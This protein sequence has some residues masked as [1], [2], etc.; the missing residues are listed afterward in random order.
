MLVFR[1]MPVATDRTI[2][3]VVWL[4][5]RL[6][7]LLLL[8]L[9]ANAL[10][11][12]DGLAQPVCSAR[13]DIG[14]NMLGTWTQ[15]RSACEED[16]R[17]YIASNPTGFSWFANAANGFAGFPYILQRV[18]P[19]L[20]PEIWGR[21]EEK[22]ARFG[23]FEDP[24]PL[25]PL[26]RGLGI[27][28]AA[29]RA[30]E[31]GAVSP[32]G[33]IDFAKPGLHVV[34]LSCGAC[35]S[36]RVRTDAGVKVIEGAP[37]T[38]MDVRKW[39]DAYNR[40]IQDYL[41]N[42]AK[43]QT[44]ARRISDIIDSK[45]EGYFY[46]SSYFNRPGFLNF[47]PAVERK[48]RES[49]KANLIGILASFACLTENRKIGQDLQRAT[50]YG[51]WNSPGLAGFST[52]QQDG[53]GDL[54]FQLLTANAMPAGECQPKPDGSG[55][56]RD[57]DAAS[58]MTS[59]HPSIPPFATITDIPSVWNQ[60]AR[61]L[62][63]WDGS[64]NSPFWRNIAAALPIV[65]D[66]ARVDLHNV[67]IVANFLHELPP[68]PYPFN[69]DI[70]RAGRGEALFREHCAICHKPN[71][72]AL[73]QYREIG[74]DMNRAA[75]L[76][77]AALDLLMTGFAASCHNPDFR[78]TLPSGQT[79]EPC[80]MQGE[81]VIKRRTTPDRQGYITNV[82]DGIWARAPYL[83]NGSVPTL[84]HLLVPSS[85]PA[86][87]LRGSTEYDQDHVGFAWELPGVGQAADTSPTLMI[88]DTS[89]AGHSNSGHDRD[90]MVDGKLRRLNW[91][92]V[93]H[94]E[95]VRDLIEYLKTQ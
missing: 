90:L 67:A 5:L 34:T 48:Q 73:Y 61:H 17:Q 88:Y 15:I 20:A 13:R 93:Q 35:H 36:G 11:P 25:R 31:A 44:T 74:T 89:R 49:V 39:R 81:A 6:S 41:S 23:Y 60:A 9:L 54:V 43:L 80:R 7:V 45:A 14:A 51:T 84:Y 59:Q 75:V 30:F 77:D 72:D 21:P 71:N 62:A 37:N 2:V 58:F 56:R 38:Q 4:R 53:S 57:F 64:V 3:P 92:G 33:E 8:C 70:T 26:P 40:T 27:A 66:P 83:H 42:P 86:Q 52:G 47:G 32:A 12:T 91:S 82:L 68:S 50:S 16:Q 63:Q 1:R 78:Y 85:R 18:L 95:A 79:V 69:V 46:P 22:F 65:G 28:S 87:F 10:A 19:D 24:D 55:L 94:L 29:G 76:N